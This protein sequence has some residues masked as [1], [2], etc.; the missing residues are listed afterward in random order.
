P[1]TA[2]FRGSPGRPAGL[3]P[4]R[5][6]PSGAGSPAALQPT[7]DGEIR[8][9]LPRRIRQASLV[10]Q[11]RDGPADGGVHEA[12]EDRSPEE[13][14]TMLTS[15]QQ[16]WLRGR[17]DAERITDDE[18]RPVEAATWRAEEEDY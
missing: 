18:V 1:P 7:R 16:G 5:A 11:L 14:R 8:P 10:P 12:S 3:P 6:Q 17:V 9:R 2:Q 4:G 15:I 13:V